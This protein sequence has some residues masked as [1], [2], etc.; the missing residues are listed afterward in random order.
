[1][2]LEKKITN[3]RIISIFAMVSSQ[4][5]IDLIEILNVPLLKSNIIRR[6]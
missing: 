4:F 5:E 2:H 1:M 3:E 6:I